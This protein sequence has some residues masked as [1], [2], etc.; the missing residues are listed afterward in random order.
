MAVM[1]LHSFLAVMIFL[2]SVSAQQVTLISNAL[3]ACAQSCPVLLQAQSACV[4]PPLGAAAVSN[5]QTYT[6]CFCQ[7]SY[8]GPLKAGTGTSVCPTCST[9]DMSTTQQWY[10]GLCGT[11]NGAATPPNGQVPTTTTSSSSTTTAPTQTTNTAK[12]TGARTAGGVTQDTSGTN[13]SW[14]GPASGFGLL[15]S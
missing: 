15:Q 8:L 3:P 9:A 6:S 2:S 11:Q 5:Q 13:R 12:P 14:Y 4:P 7:S 10:N 1:S